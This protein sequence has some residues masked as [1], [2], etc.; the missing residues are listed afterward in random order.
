MALDIASK[1]RRKNPV[2]RTPLPTLPPGKRSRAALGLTAAAA[3]G[4]LEL[5]VCQDC[6][7]TQYPPRWKVRGSSRWLGGHW[8]ARPSRA[9]TRQR[10][11]PAGL[12]FAR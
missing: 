4:R 12:R 2:L 5:Q 10:K 8:V 6:G 3:R 11:S 7:A 1:P 9:M